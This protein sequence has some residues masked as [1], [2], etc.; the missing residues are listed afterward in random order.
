MRPAPRLAGVLVLLALA[1]ATVPALATHV[2]DHRFI[3][4]GLVTDEAG[5]P[6]ASVPVV[7]TRLKTGLAHRTRTE[8]DGLYVVVVHIH[9]DDEG[10][11]LSVS[12]SGASGE[13][14]TRFDVHDRRTERGTRV[15]VR[16]GA[17]VEDRRA[18]AEMLRA[19]LAR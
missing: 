17:V 14:V 2:P 8:A 1:V 13:V 16:G 9:D 7:V 6:L 3:V 12:A 10:E 5:R 19:Y 18:F 11:R 15:D 4:L